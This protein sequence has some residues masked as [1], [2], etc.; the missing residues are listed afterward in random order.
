MEAKLAADPHLISPTQYARLT[1]LSRS[2]VYKKIKAGL[3]DS[4]ETPDGLKV[5]APADFA[6]TGAKASQAVVTNTVLL[7]VTQAAIELR[8]SRSEVRALADLGKLTRVGTGPNAKVLG[9][10]VRQL[11]AA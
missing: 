4:F 1:G 6:S 7:T 10:D 5:I 8:L 2:G 3:L 11:L 9:S